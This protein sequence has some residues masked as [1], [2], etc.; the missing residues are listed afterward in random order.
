MIMPAPEGV[1]ILPGM[2][3]TVTGSN[4]KDTLSK[5]NQLIPINA[6]FADEAGKNY[7]WLVEDSMEIKKQAVDAGTVTGENI[8]IKG[9]NPGNRIVTAGVNYLSPG[10]KVR[11]IN[12][13]K[14][15]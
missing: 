8:Y 1:N 10:M 6:V 15:D 7:V 14:K 3:A 5:Q 2:T 13:N 9:L 11:E 4:L 12:V